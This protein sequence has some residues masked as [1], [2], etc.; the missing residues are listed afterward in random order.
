MSKSYIIEWKSLVNGRTGRGTKLFD[1]EEAK[2]LAEELNREY[3]GIHHQAIETTLPNQTP[4]PPPSEASEPVQ[5]ATR[6][7]VAE[8]NQS[9]EYVLS[10]A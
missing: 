9:P 3:P 6:P 4:A 7:R 10:A 5:T 1:E 8:L 2:N